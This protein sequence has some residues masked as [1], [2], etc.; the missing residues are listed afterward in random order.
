M[1]V[2]IKKK[3]NSK[4]RRMDIRLKDLYI[5]QALATRHA[6][7]VKSLAE[8]WRSVPQLN[9][10]VGL[11]GWYQTARQS[12]AIVEAFNLKPTGDV[13]DE[14]PRPPPPV[15]VQAPPPEAGK[16]LGRD[17][18]HCL[19]SCGCR[20][21]IDLVKPPPTDGSICGNCNSNTVIWNLDMMANK[22]LRK[23]MEQG[24]RSKNLEWKETVAPGVEIWNGIEDFPTEEKYWTAW[25][26]SLVTNKED[27]LR[28]IPKGSAWKDYLGTLPGFTQFI[29]SDIPYRYVERETCKPLRH[30][31]ETSGAQCPTDFSL[32]D[33]RWYWNPKQVLENSDNYNGFSLAIFD[34]DNSKT[35]ESDNRDY[36]CI[37]TLPLTDEL[38]VD[39][40]K[41]D[42][43]LISTCG[44]AKRQSCAGGRHYPSE[45]GAHCASRSAATLTEFVVNKKATSYS[46]SYPISYIN[47]EKNTAHTN[48]TCYRDVHMVRNTKYQ[49]REQMQNDIKL[50]EKMILEMKSRLA[51]MFVVVHFGLEKSH[52]VFLTF[53]KAA[54]RVRD[55]KK[56]WPNCKDEFER[57][58]L[59]YACGTGEMKN[60][61]QLYSHKDGN[62]SH[63]VETMTVFGRVPCNETADATSIVK[64]MEPALLVLPYQQLV[65]K[66]KAGDVLHCKFI[67]TYHVPDCSRNTANYS[68]VHGP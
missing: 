7:K 64:G 4:P 8:F 22:S 38:I 49:K 42:T 59:E 63:L 55:N 54:L 47:V 18:K 35:G 66:L 9:E 30:K 5:Q 14:V 40:A 32:D 3:R 45:Q 37:G 13:E 17:G 56:L 52:D 10:A 1:N 60:F 21:H 62:A 44:Y 50:Q 65:C 28:P 51:F 29:K 36:A 15:V 33:K 19:Y 48:I 27:K 61:Q 43:A 2:A 26:R 67:A 12:E 34:G 20:L 53:A 11:S 23:L 41:K 58:L 46:T 6:G 57:V 68:C 31:N 39:I 25:M 24:A 16:Y